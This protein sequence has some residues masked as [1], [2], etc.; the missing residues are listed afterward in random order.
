MIKPKR[1]HRVT[2]HIREIKSDEVT[3]GKIYNWFKLY[4]MSKFGLIITK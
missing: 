2:G 3:R 1:K 4:K